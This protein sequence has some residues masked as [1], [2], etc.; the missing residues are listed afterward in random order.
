M[1]NN[2]KMD[3]NQKFERYKEP[4]N[5]F[6]I[7]GKLVVIVIVLAV[8]VVESMYTLR[9]TETA[10]VT[11]F[12]VAQ[13]NDGKGLQ[14]KIP[15][16]QEVTKVDTTIKGFSLGYIQ[17]TDGTMTDVEK[18]STMITS[19]YNFINADFYVSYE[20]TDPIKYLY[21]SNRPEEI[22]KNVTQ[23]CVRST[24]SAYT[25]DSA[26]TTGKS[27]IQANIKQMIVNKLEQA[28]IGITLID[29]SMQDVEP[30]TEEIKNAF[31]EVET[32]KQQKES[33]INE[34]NQYRNEQLPAA[35]AK[36]DKILQDAEAQK[37]SR[38]NEAVGQVARF[39]KEYEEYCKYPLI[40]KR[41]MFYETMEQVLPNLKV[42][43]E[44]GDGTVEKIYPV[45]S[46]SGDVNVT[47][48]EKSDDA[49]EE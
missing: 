45:D 36:S 27:E 12:G 21:N 22:L 19:D 4:M 49:K 39:E 28:D 42:V 41:R 8:L 37:V 16:F 11:T 14:F 15:F 26:L 43:I 6:G 31:K 29:I 17:N 13:I 25:V 46:F 18:E 47:A 44:S 10:V 2:G 3:N 5:K 9:E 32:A 30:P 48:P 40:T 23:N 35:E 20:V 1:D 7:V 33:L 24:M 38:T 34:A